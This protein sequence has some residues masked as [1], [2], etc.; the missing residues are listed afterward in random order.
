MGFFSAPRI[1]FLD[2][3]NNWRRVVQIGR[4]DDIDR[5]FDLE[6]F[7]VILKASPHTGKGDVFHSGISNALRSLVAG[8]DARSLANPMVES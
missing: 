4:V 5:G 3:L 7:D 1:L 2:I 8:N 6:I